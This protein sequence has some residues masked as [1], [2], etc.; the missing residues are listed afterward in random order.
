MS[1]GHYDAETYSTA[2]AWR[3]A[4]LTRDGRCVACHATGE[5]SAHHLIHKRHCT[6]Q[7]KLDPRNGA[8]LCADFTPQHCHR[9]LHDGRLKLLPSMLAPEVIECLAEQGLRWIDGE[10]FGPCRSYFGNAS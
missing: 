5:L 7:Y 8:A 9:S 4:V 2:R 1:K 6:E 3:E 10:P